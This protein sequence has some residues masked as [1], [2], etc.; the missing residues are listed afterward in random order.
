MVKKK[1][2]MADF[3]AAQQFSTL[4]SKCPYDM[5]LG[6][7]RYLVDAKSIVGI[8]S[9]DL[10]KEMELTA[11]TDDEAHVDEVFGRFIVG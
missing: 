6:Q 10:S 3:L 5:D 4:C 1:V 2:I 8:Y 9:L 11:N 7:G